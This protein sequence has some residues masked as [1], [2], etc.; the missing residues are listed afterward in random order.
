MAEPNCNL[1]AKRLTFACRFQ[2]PLC[3][4]KRPEFA[5][6]G[7]GCTRFKPKPQELPSS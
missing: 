1:C 6:N 3:A 4:E 5:S 7:I 2:P